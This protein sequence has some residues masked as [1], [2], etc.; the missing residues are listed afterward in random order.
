MRCRVPQPSTTTHPN[1]R[2]AYVQ[3]CQEFR[4]AHI[5]ENTFWRPR[6]SQVAIDNG[7]SSSS[8]FLR[9]PVKL[10]CLTRTTLHQ[11]SSPSRG[12]SGPCKSVLSAVGHLTPSA[13]AT[14]GRCQVVVSDVP[15]SLGQ[16][17]LSRKSACE[18]IGLPESN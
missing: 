8:I 12:S 17:P 3:A 13:C 15:A 18:R 11:V 14:P 16:R 2:A 6:K 1:T 4:L 9:K 7:C 5:L 10:A